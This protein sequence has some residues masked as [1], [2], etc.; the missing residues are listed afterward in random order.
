M[1]L[2]HINQELKRLTFDVALPEG[3]PDV[4]TRRLK[5]LDHWLQDI[6]GEI[7]ELP[8]TSVATSS[9]LEWEVWISYVSRG[10]AVSCHL[11]QL[12][13]IPV[14]HPGVLENLSPGPQSGYVRITASVPFYELYPL[15][16]YQSA[17]SL[18]FD[19]LSELWNLLPQ[20]ED[21]ARIQDLI[22]QQFVQPWRELKISSDSCVPIL[23]EA[24]LR[25]IPCRQLSPN[26]FLLGWGA[27]SHLIQSSAVDTSS[28]L[29]AS[30]AQDKMQTARIL[31]ALGLPAPIHR[32][33]STLQE[34]RD[35]ALI[36]GFPVVVKP[37]DRDRGEGVTINV[38]NMDKLQQ[39]WL[40]ARSYSANILVEKQIPGVCHRLYLVEGKLVFAI[41][42][43]PKSVKGDGIHS[44]RQLIDRQNELQSKLPPWQ[45][46]QPFLADGLSIQ[47]LA[48]VGLTL[49]TVIPEDLW[50]ELRPVNT[51]EWDGVVENFTEKIHSDNIGIAKSLVDAL[52]LTV[53]GVDMMSQDIEVAWHE[54]G[55]II[56]EVNHAPFSGSATAAKAILESIFQD[57]GRLPI[58]VYVGGQTAVNVACD[59]QKKAAE[60]GEI[61]GLIKGGYCSVVHGRQLLMEKCDLFSCCRSAL[62]R[63]ELQGLLVVVDEVQELLAELPFD[64]VSLVYADETVQRT[65]IE[66]LSALM[67]S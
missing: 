39:A 33:A 10:L 66:K 37:N 67:K 47:C 42:R 18:A 45:R 28:A 34:A 46:R 11:L 12:I 20:T 41:R 3:S 65:A 52:G 62:I 56:H 19:L 5:N 49:D 1:Y 57:D 53:A 8:E 30:I 16:A 13:R 63:K 6:F 9:V 51:V 54:N 29:G 17:L 22:H 25:N 38:T 15:P 7:P 43:R 2:P 4:W 55:G 48:E 44:I 59:R 61:F 35:A 32:P 14:F 27:K 50:A 23:R 26:T 64:S 21:C 36:L 24:Y 40:K 58:E 60:R 31:K